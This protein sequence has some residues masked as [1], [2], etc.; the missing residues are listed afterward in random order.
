[1]PLCITYETYAVTWPLANVRSSVSHFGW[2][3]K[4]QI[5]YNPNSRTN[6]EDPTFLNHAMVLKAFRLLT[7]ILLSWVWMGGIPPFLWVWWPSLLPPCFCC[8]S[9]DTSSRISYSWQPV[10]LLLLLHSCNSVVLL[11]CTGWNQDTS[12]FRFDLLVLLG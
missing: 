6:L 2:I 7:E 5:K 3:F 10:W 4:Q 11:M 8:L 9:Q 12:A 1:M